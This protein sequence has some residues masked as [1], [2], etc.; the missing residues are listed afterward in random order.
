MTN[1]EL[2]ENYDV[3]K[4]IINLVNSVEYLKLFDTEKRNVSIKEI[5]NKFLC[6][7]MVVAN[8]MAYR[9]AENEYIEDCKKTGITH[10]W[11]WWPRALDR[12]DEILKE[13]GENG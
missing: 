6:E 12:R 7:R 4:E 3:L 1:K 8:L 9:I 5:V 2:L 13:W 11:G 10:A